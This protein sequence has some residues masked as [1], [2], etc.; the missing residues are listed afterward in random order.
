MSR[1]LSREWENEQH[2]QLDGHPDDRCGTE[3]PCGGCGACMHAQLSYYISK[4]R[5]W[6]RTVQRAG[7]LLLNPD[8]VTIPWEPGMS[9]GHAS[10]DCWNAGEIHDTEFPWKKHPK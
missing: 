8:V 5:D 2:E 1:Y 3:V 9:S 4:E 10:Y 7:F 6:A